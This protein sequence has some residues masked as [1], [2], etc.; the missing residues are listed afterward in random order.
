VSSA[1]GSGSSSESDGSTAA[2]PQS[3]P[4]ATPPPTA[5]TGTTDEEPP[6]ATSTG[7]VTSPGTATSIALL[8]AIRV[9]R[10]EGYD[11]VVFQFTNVVPGYRVEYVQPPLVE[12]GSGDRVDVDGKAFVLVRMEQASGFDLETGEG[13]IVYKGPRRISGSEAGTSSVRELV[14]TGDFEAVLSWAV[15]LADRVGFRVLT[16]QDPPR[17][18]I[19]FRHQ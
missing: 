11:R 13:E 15:G 8:E 1:C 3:S 16:L 14:R 9:A 4:P 10:H 12:D 5:P 7:P 17:L 19:D 6:G 2:V 18:V